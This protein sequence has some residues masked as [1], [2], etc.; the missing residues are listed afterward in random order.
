MA[1]VYGRMQKSIDASTLTEMKDGKLLGISFC[2]PRNP[3]LRNPLKGGRFYPI[4]R[5]TRSRFLEPA[6]GRCPH[7]T[8]A[9]SR[10]IA[11]RWGEFKEP[12]AID[13]NR[14]DALG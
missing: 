10:R 4:L 5:R 14:N 9:T 7:N 3:R 8:F 1:L 6:K 12:P 2:V 11:R 13:D